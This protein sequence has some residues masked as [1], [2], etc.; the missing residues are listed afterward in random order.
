MGINIEDLNDLQLQLK[1]GRVPQ[2]GQCDALI[3][4]VWRLKTLVSG[5][6]I[7][8]QTAR[9]EARELEKLLEALISENDALRAEVEE[10]KAV[11]G[12]PACQ[13]EGRW[14]NCAVRMRK[15]GSR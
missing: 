9:D 10:L 6:T 14:S 11:H 1:Q 7:E 15:L 2:A 3:A 5:K 13:L 12:L 4:E 8:M